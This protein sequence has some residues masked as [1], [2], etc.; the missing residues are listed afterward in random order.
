M[1]E[2][3]NGGAIMLEK[4]LLPSWPEILGQLGEPAPRRNRTKCPIHGGDSPTSLSLSE[5]KGVFHCFVCGAKGGKLDF[6]QQV[7]KCDFKDALAFLGIQT[8]SK[9]PKPD[10]AVIRQR[11]ALEAI[12]AWVKSTGRRLRDELY[13]REM[14]I[15]RATRRLRRDSGDSWGWNW[16]AWAY[17]G[18]DALEYL[19][20][21]IGFCRTDSERLTAWREYHH[22][23]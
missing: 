12:R 23:L 7:Q 16:L 13:V 20:D 19:H 10:P 5:D 17:A 1:V 9:P 15:T 18:K 3:A 8:N 14:L 11:A 2:T 6:V 21:E 22:V 4:Q